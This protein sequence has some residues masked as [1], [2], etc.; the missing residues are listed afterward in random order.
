MHKLNGKQGVIIPQSNVKNL[1]LDEEVIS[2][3]KK[4]KFNIWAVDKIEDGIRILTGVNAGQQ[5]KDGSFTKDSIFAKVQERITE[6][7][8][9]SKRFGKTLDKDIQADLKEEKEEDEKED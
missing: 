4:G 8:R 5:R 7:S 2:A 1:M 6:F 9:R 3:V